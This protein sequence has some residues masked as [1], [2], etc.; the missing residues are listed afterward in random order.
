M[1]ARAC[2]DIAS[3]SRIERRERAWHRQ[4]DIDPVL[5]TS[6]CPLPHIM[7][8]DH[9]RVTSSARGRGIVST[10]TRVRPAHARIPCRTVTYMLESFGLMR[11]SVTQ[12]P[13][14]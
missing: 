4:Y 14:A 7:Y 13:N 3:R 8:I 12:D 2:G 5:S 9:D 10:C 1:R 6:A 11:E